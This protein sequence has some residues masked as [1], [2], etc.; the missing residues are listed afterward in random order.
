MAVKVLDLI[1]KTLADLLA[2]VIPSLTCDCSL[3][4]RRLCAVKV[5]SNVESI[6]GDGMICKADP[7]N[8]NSNLTQMGDR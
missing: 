1:K 7:R 3:N 5:K 6:A 4:K 2:G 8:L